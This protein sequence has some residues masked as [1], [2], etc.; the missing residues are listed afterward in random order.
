[1]E[2]KRI[3]LEE[4]FE[5]EKKENTG[6]LKLIETENGN[7]EKQLQDLKD[8][9]HRGNSHFDDITEYKNE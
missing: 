3:Q 5:K 2:E 8:R 9:P 7:I 4:R 1:M 6:N